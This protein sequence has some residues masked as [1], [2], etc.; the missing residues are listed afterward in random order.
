MFALCA[1]PALAAI[2]PAKNFLS[3]H[4]AVEA[5][6]DQKLLKDKEGCQKPREK[7]EKRQNTEKVRKAPGK[8][9]VILLI[10][11]KVASDGS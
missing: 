5:K 2:L 6:K 4:L 9:V 11:G 10:S 1:V 3:Y 8:G 7:T